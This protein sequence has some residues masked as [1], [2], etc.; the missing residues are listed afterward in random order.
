MPG[1]PGWVPDSKAGLRAAPLE[2]GHEGKPDHTLRYFTA[3]RGEAATGFR[4]DEA[5]E[6]LLCKGYIV[7]TVDGVS[8][9][10]EASFMG[11]E[12]EH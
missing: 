6:A 11:S 4:F 10:E 9:A 1:L 7:A 3:S 12:P 8:R 2:P 5:L